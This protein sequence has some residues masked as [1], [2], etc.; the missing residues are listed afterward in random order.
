MGYPAGEARRHAIAATSREYFLR[1]R[2]AQKIMREHKPKPQRAG[3]SRVLR[4]L[5]HRRPAD[6]RAS[7][8]DYPQHLVDIAHPAEPLPG[9]ARAVLAEHHEQVL[10]PQHR[11]VR[12]VHA[13]ARRPGP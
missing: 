12:I 6:R 8:S 11:D 2:G 1:Q 13:N 5:E 9:V 4:T 10:N 7:I 3:G